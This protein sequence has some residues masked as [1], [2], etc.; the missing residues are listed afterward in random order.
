MEEFPNFFVS[1]NTLD[2]KKISRTKIEKIP[3]EMFLI[4]EDPVH[5]RTSDVS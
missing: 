5:N 2:L 4:A 1:R 3:S